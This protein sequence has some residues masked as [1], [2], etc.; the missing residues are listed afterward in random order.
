LPES[1]GRADDPWRSSGPGLATRAA[2]PDIR[3]RR[4]RQ[5]ESSL[6]QPPQRL[7]FTALTSSG[8]STSPRTWV[9]LITSSL[10]IIRANS[11]RPCRRKQANRA[12]FSRLA[13]ATL[14][15]DASCDV[16][17]RSR[18]VLYRQSGRAPM[19]EGV[20]T[21]SH[22]ATDA[23]SQQGWMHA[24]PASPTTL[25]RDVAPAEVDKGH[26]ECDRYVCRAHGE[27]QPERRRRRAT[28]G[29]DLQRRTRE[30]LLGVGN[31][32]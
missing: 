23:S 25:G 12:Q 4:R 31:D 7:T 22:G 8:S 9:H 27:R 10:Q 26:A 32:P 11:I 3:S 19:A 6:K 18:I 29:H 28:L 14:A 1:V 24:D 5:R 16:G 30:P 15:Q 20:T 13:D 2:E 17:N 21:P